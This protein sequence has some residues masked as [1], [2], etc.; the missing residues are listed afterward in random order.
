MARATAA[1]NQ[2]YVVNVNSGAPRAKG[3]TIVCGPGGEVI[4]Q[5]G[6]RMQP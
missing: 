6:D 5:S 1:Q 2:C 4:Y 3:K